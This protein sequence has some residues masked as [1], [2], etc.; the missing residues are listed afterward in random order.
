MK[1]YMAKKGEIK[2]QWFVADANEKVLGRVATRVAVILSGKH[3][4]TY[5]PH[6][7]TGDFVIV[8]NADRVRVTGKRR[9]DK[10]Y[11]TYSGYPGGLKEMNFETLMQRKPKEAVKLAVKNMLPKSK[12]GKKM[13][14]KL[15]LY[16]QSEKPNVP[17][18]AKEIAI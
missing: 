3:K 8:L 10:I 6:V 1:T 16:T 11:R 9:T 5:T 14:K 15:R 18:G 17:K 12:L 2:R 13:F 4:P 7:D